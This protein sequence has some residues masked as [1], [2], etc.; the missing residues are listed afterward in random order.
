MSELKK[1]GHQELDEDTYLEVAKNALI[2][3][4]LFIVVTIALWGYVYLILLERGIAQ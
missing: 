1:T 2:F 3:A 4:L